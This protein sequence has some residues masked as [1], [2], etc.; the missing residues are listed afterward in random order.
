MNPENQE[1]K[2]LANWFE[3]LGYVHQCLHAEVFLGLKEFACRVMPHSGATTT[4]MVFFTPMPSA[5]SALASWVCQKLDTRTNEPSLVLQGNK[6]WQ[7]SRESIND[8]HAKGKELDKNWQI[9]RLPWSQAPIWI[10]LSFFPG[11]L[12]PK[13]EMIFMCE[14][15]IRIKHADHL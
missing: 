1:W 7:L 10:S 9:F 3:G 4:L 14:L 6:V 8:L 11:T 15:I 13:E 2:A 5:Q 12:S